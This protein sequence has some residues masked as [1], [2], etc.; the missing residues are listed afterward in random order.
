M[1]TQQGLIPC[2]VLTGGFMLC[3][4]CGQFNAMPGKTLC[5]RCATLYDMCKELPYGHPIEYAYERYYPYNGW[6]FDSKFLP[7]N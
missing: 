4:G 5:R 7:K 1:K 2:C 3:N 6:L